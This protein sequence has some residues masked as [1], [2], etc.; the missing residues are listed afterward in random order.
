[1]V[2]VVANS[3]VFGSVEL[4]RATGSTSSVIHCRK[5]IQAA[6]SYTRRSQTSQHN[7]TMNKT[8]RA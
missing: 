2:Q 5:S 8:K 1:M 4:P 3:I 7:K 6:A